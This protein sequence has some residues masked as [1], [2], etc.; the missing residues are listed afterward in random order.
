MKQIM[1]IVC[2]SNREC[3]LNP[4]HVEDITESNSQ[5]VLVAM[6]S[7]KQHGLS[8][9]EKISSVIERWKTALG[10]E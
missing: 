9:C 7:G 2:A 8:S 3:F 5:Q 10:I 1:R 6:I 4:D